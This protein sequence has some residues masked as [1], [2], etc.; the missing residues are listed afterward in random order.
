MDRR[1]LVIAGG[2]LA[3]PTTALRAQSFHLDQSR[4]IAHFPRVDQPTRFCAHS[5]NRHRECWVSKSSSRVSGALAE[6]SHR[7][8]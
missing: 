6:L 5:W 8:Q 7:S 4:C 3:L 1:T 2:A